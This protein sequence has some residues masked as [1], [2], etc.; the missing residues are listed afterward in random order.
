LISDDG[1]QGFNER[2]YAVASVGAEWRLTRAWAVRGRY[3]YSWQDYDLTPGS[4]SSNALRLSVTFQPQ[5]DVRDQGS[6]LD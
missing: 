4:A 1:P 2:R 3:D 6:L 5:R